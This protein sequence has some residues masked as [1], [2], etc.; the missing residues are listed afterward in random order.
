MIR[1]RNHNDFTL[2]S[3]V[4]LNLVK[5]TVVHLA[6][7]VLLAGS[8]GV[9]AQ[10]AQKAYRVGFVSIS[11]APSFEAF[12]QGLRQLGYV[13]GR[14]V[15]FEARFA[16]RLERFP[17]LAAELIRL[18]VDVLLA[19]SPAGAMAAKKSS[20][21]VPIVIAG[22]GDP[23]ASGIVASL[24]R[25]G[26]NITGT[27]VGIGDPAFGGK[28]LEMLKETLPGLSHVAVLA[29]R[30]NKT[31]AAY[32]EGVEAAA[33]TSH[34]KI[35]IFDAANPTELDRALSAIGNS[36]AQGIIVTTDPFLFSS[37]ETLVQFAAA[38]RLPATYFFKQFADAGGLMSYGASLE[39]S[40][41]RAATYVDKILKGARP[42]DL[43][44]EQPRHFELVINMKT[45][46]ALGLKVPQLLLLR[47]YHVIE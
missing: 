8:A 12:R 40:Y 36:S 38:K 25:P 5:R 39:D 24:A 42:A 20:T 45:A 6:A 26:G 46:R 10:P 44:I 43:P 15:I 27:A 18:K 7:I 28:W 17:E 34:V 3:F 14:N 33:R 35:A 2:G 31:N 22:V 23:V 19:G 41:R 16:D 4:A 32:L 1:R 30:S 47:A 29:N 11:G 21:T 13:E 9:H 37:R